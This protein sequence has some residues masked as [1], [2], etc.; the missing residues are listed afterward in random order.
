VGVRYDIMYSWVDSYTRERNVRRICSFR[1]KGDAN[2]FLAQ[3]KS[4][5]VTVY[6]GVDNMKLYPNDYELYILEVA[7]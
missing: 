6:H 5:E 7:C 3:L 4:G 2:L 1:H